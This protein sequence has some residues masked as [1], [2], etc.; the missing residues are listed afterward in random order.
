MA[1]LAVAFFLPYGLL[2]AGLGSAFPVQGGPY[3]WTRL[4]FGRL[5]AGL[6]QILY[7]ISN[8]VWVGGS[9]GIIALTTWEE[10]FTPL[11]GGWKYAAGLVFIW[12]GAPTAR[13]PSP[14]PTG[15]VRPGSAPSPRSTARRYG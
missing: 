2:V 13:R 1:I 11:P 15:R 7:W 14:A 12:G 4:A 9:L 8:P 10:F 5:T 6:N 3:V